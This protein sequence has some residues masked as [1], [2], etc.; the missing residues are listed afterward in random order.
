VLISNPEVTFRSGSSIA[1]FL[2]LFASKRNTILRGG[3][4]KLQVITDFDKTLTPLRKADGKPAPTSY[5]KRSWI[6]CTF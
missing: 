2:Q 5:C 1:E 3:V 6:L 4:G